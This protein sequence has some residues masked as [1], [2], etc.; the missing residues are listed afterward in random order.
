M[1]TW[2]DYSQQVLK[3]ATTVPAPEYW[4]ALRGTITPGV[5]PLA[6]VR[7]RTTRAACAELTARAIIS[8]GRCPLNPV[9]A[10]VT[11]DQLPLRNNRPDVAPVQRPSSKAISPLTITVW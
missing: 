7:S 5:R 6:K 8:R 9:Q 1:V 10:C 11:E 4:A 3:T 2:R